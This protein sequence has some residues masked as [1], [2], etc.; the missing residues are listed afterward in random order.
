VTVSADQQIQEANPIA[1]YIWT[2]EETSDDKKHENEALNCKHLFPADQA[3][4]HK[5]TEPDL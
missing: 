4:K 2:S 5:F 3:A 1:I